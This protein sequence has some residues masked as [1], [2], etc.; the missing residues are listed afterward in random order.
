M[1]NSS[2][3]ENRAIELLSSYSVKTAGGI[4]VSRAH[5][6]L[7][8]WWYANNQ[9]LVFIADAPLTAL[10]ANYPGLVDSKTVLL[11]IAERP[12]WKLS[13]PFIAPNG[14]IEFADG[15]EIVG[16]K[17]RIK[18]IAKLLGGSA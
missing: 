7:D 11:P 8:G 13:A 18:Q 3:R 10:T 5:L 9:S 16:Q 12:N 17:S 6:V 14:I 1:N 2:D 15:V 4:M